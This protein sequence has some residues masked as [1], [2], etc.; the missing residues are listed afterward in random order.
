LLGFDELTEDFDRVFNDDPNML[1]LLESY[2]RVRGKNL[3][4]EL[5]LL[6]SSYPLDL[7]QNKNTRKIKP[8]EMANE[9]P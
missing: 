4:K 5:I 9:P 8:E 3:R 6:H 2:R 1:V 7:K